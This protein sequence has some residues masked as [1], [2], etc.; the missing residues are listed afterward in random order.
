[1]KTKQNKTHV[2]DNIELLYPHDFP[3]HRPKA[4]TII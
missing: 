1:M 2:R 3:S 4:G